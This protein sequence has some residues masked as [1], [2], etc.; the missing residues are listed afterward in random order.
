MG[1]SIGDGIIVA[2]IAAAIVA[3][4]FLKAGERQRRLEIIHQ[5]RVVAMEKGIALPDLP[6]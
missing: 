3:Y 2:A 4:L 5:E 1:H 6:R